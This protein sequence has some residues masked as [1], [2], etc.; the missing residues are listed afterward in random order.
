MKLSM[1]VLI[2]SCA[3][4]RAL[5]TPATPPHAAPA[6]AARERGRAGAAARRQER[7]RDADQR[8]GEAAEIELA[9]DADV[10]QPGAE[11]ERHREPGEDQRR[12]AEQRLADA[13][14]GAEALA[15]HQRVDL[16]RL[17]ADAAMK[18]APATSASATESSG[19]ASVSTGAGR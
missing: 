7:Q 15:E 2:T 9:L 10:E 11:P 1:I 13:V 4:K 12:G 5:S 16:E 19:A 8:R 17:L 3:P 18:T 6:A 14:A